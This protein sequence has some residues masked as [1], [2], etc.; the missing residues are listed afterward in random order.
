[1]GVYDLKSAEVSVITV[2]VNSLY[3]TAYL[4]INV[5]LQHSDD[6]LPVENFD[7]PLRFSCGNLLLKGS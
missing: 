2:L 6:F 1:L 7:F 5:G 4:K 3:L